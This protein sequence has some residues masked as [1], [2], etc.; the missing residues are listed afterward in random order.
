M[1]AGVGSF[2]L[3]LAPTKL[4][5]RLP[6]VGIACITGMKADSGDEIADLLRNLAPGLCD[7]RLNEDFTLRLFTFGSPVLQS[8]KRTSRPCV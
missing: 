1:A 8:R 3:R 6:D 2:P 4:S 7:T 5:G